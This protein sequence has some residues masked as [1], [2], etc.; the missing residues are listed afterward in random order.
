MLKDDADLDRTGVFFGECLQGIQGCTFK[1]WHSPGYWCSQSASQLSDA[2]SRE[3]VG[4]KV[5]SGVIGAQ[6]YE[7]D[8]DLHSCKPEESGSGEESD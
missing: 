4:H 7:D 2:S 5:Y 1:G 6:E 3:R 8:G